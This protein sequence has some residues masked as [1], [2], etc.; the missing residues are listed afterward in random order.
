MGWLYNTDPNQTKADYVREILARN[1]TAPY[2]VEKH[3]LVGNHLWAIMSHSEHGRAIVL[4]LLSKDRGGGWGCK[5]MTESMGPAY[6]TCPLSFLDAVPVAD[7]PYAADWRNK[8]RA[9]HANKAKRT[10]VKVGNVVRFTDGCRFRGAPVERAKVVSLKPLVVEID[11]MVV[12][13][14]RGMIAEVVA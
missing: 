12:S 7:G 4:F 9:Y 10:K 14:K 5:D 13:A 2:T 6:Y 3:A 1:F 8:V 11:G